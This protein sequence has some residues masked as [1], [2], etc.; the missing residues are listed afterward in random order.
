M[1]NLGGTGMGY[2]KTKFQKFYVKY[3]IKSP[4]IFYTFLVFGVVC[5]LYISLTTMVDTSDGEIS[6]LK[7]IITK[8]GKG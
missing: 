8:A 4:L 5:F 2:K 1:I 6:L 3:I 7:L